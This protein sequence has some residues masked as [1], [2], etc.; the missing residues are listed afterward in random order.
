MNKTEQLKKEIEK[1]NPKINGKHF[2]SKESCGYED[3]KGC[4]KYFELQAELKGRTEQK[5]EDF[6][7]LERVIDKI[8]D[9]LCHGTYVCNY[10][11]LKLALNQQ[12]RR[13]EKISKN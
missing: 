2:H 1:I 9:I 13:N 4:F 10:K 8:G 11:E 5:Q 6:E 3:Y 7:L 12:R